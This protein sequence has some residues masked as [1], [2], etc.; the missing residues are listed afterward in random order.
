L[1]LAN[2]WTIGKNYGHLAHG[3]CVT[4]Y[5]SQG[6]TVDRLFLGISSASFPAAS[7]QQF[8]VSVSRGR[9]GATIYTDDKEALLDA[10][11]HSDDRV[12]A[13]ELVSGHEIR[14]RGATLQ[15]I[16]RMMPEITVP[17]HVAAKE[18][19]GLNYDR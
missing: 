3:Y 14:E 1:V 2:G 6:K 7:R 17:A 13:T 10:V 8:Y 15:R 19:E 9:K 4:S 12:T 11:S 18:R 5:A 16:E